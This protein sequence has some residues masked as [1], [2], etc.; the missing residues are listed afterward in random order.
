MWKKIR[1]RITRPIYTIPENFM[2]ICPGVFKF[3]SKKKIIIIIEKKKP[4]NN[5]KVL[6][7]KNKKETVENNKVFR[8][9]P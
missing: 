7:T 1:I 5:N 6:I 4:K 9:R 2:K 8:W 3:S